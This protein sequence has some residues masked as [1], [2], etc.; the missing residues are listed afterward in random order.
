[1]VP[2]ESR[3]AP[4]DPKKRQF[5][6]GNSQRRRIKDFFLSQEVYEICSIITDTFQ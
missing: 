1:M 5:D 6:R 4:L 2:L 3:A